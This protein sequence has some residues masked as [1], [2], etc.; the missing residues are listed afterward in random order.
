L[1]KIQKEALDWIVPSLASV[2]N[3]ILLEIM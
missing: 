2:M 3:N 1:Q